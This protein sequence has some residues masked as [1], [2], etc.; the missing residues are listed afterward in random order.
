MYAELHALTSFS[1]LRGA[2]QPDEMVLQAA[3]LGY[4][5]LAITDE[6]S[7]AGVVRA[8][9]AAKKAGLPLIIGAEF[10]CLDGLKFVALATDR[11][12][13]GALCRLVS[14]ARRATAKG[15]Y[16]LE[17]AA[18]DHMLDGCLVIWLPRAAQVPQPQHEEDGRWLR[19]RFAG[20]LWI[21]VELLADGFEARRLGVLE[22]LGRTLEL[23]RVAC[24]DVHMHRRSRRA[25]QDVMTAIR[26]NTPLHAAGYA[27]YSNGERCL[28]PLRRL[29]ELYPAPLLEQTLGVAERCTFTLDELRYEYPQE[30]VAR[31]RNPDQSSACADA[32]RLRRAMADRRASRHA[33]CDRA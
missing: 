2:S 8:H 32:A 13:Y 20:R 5:A 3:A 23:P 4:R 16:A 25:L 31:G 19:E 26:L 28:R 29:Q 7:V 21:G 24:G 15:S 27:L 17:R 18:L 33:R 12:A 30:I 10:N 1:F 6:C 9:V 14:R 22:A 11:A